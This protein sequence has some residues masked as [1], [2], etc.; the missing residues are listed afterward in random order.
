FDINSESN[1]VVNTSH[2][3]DPIE[4]NDR[5]LKELAKPD[6]EPAQSY[7][8]KS[9]LIHLFPKFHD[10]AGEDLHKHLKEFHLVCSTMRPHGI[11][12]DYINIK[13]FMFFLNG[14][15]KD[16]LYL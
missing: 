11:P 4:N 7:E 8:L 9:V 3:L 14:T 16:W 10:L 13:A 6:L 1:I 12:K 15:A 2:E 5:T